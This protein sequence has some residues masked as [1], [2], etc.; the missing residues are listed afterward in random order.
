MRLCTAVRDSLLSEHVAA[1]YHEL[2]RENFGGDVIGENVEEFLKDIF[3]LPEDTAAWVLD[4][5][6]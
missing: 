2:L 4:E 5:L 6:R 1:H 3:E